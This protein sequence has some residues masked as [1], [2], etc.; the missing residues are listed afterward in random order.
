M[1]SEE[2]KKTRAMSQAAIDPLLF[3]QCH[4]L[5]AYEVAELLGSQWETG[6]TTEEAAARRTRFGPNELPM[7]KQRNAWMQFLLQFH[8]PLIYI[9]LAATVITALLQEWVDA[10]VIFGVVL[11]NAVV[12]FIQEAKAENAIAALTRV[13]TTEATVVRERR[14]RRIPSRELTLGDILL[15]ASGDKVPADVR[16]FKVRDL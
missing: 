12:G 5:P 1:Q 3:Q 7:Q 14:K 4:H 9:L 8:Q 6:L 11:V 16:L 15:L 13:V 2:E 10:S